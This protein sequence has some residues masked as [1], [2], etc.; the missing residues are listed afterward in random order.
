MIGAFIRGRVSLPDDGHA[1]RVFL[2]A[3]NMV[4]RDRAAKARLRYA[5]N[6]DQAIITPMDDV[7]ESVS[8]ADCVEQLLREDP[9]EGADCAV[10][11]HKRMTSLLRD[12][13]AVVG[14]AILSSDLPIQ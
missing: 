8:L 7:P 3:R 13:A 10:G 6:D 12:V 2:D 1:K 9:P 14:Q 4:R 11:S 5:L